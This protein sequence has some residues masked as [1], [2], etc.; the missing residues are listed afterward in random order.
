MDKNIGTLGKY[1]QRWLW[2]LICIV[3]PFYLSLKKK[4]K[5]Y[6]LS[7]DN[8]NLKWGGGNHY[9]ISVFFSNTR[10][11]QLLAPLEIIMSKISLNYIPIHIHN[12]EYEI[13]QPWLPVSQKYK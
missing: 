8:K 12:Y 9:E 4:S 1:D 5:K 11:T 13:I 3:N 7:L 2:K 6:N 10:W